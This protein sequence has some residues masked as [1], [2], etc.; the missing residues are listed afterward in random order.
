MTKEELLKALAERGIQVNIHG[1][2][3]CGSP[4]VEVMIDGQEVFNEDYADMSN[5]E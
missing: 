3:C 5:I 4:W 1:C 2:G